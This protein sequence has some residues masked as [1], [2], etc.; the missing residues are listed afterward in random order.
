MP[1]NFFLKMIQNLRQNEEI[2]LYGNVLNISEQDAHDVV[3]FLKNE[4]RQEALSYPYEAPI[5][6]EN[7]ALWAAKLAYIA[8][9]LILYRK[10]DDAD[11]ETLLPDYQNIKT[12]SSI[13]SAD[14]CLR[15]LPDMII[16]LKIIDS[17]DRLIEVLENHLFQA[18]FSGLNYPLDI[19]KMDF[20]NIDA[21]KCVMQLFC[22]RIIE[23]KYLKLAEHSVFKDWIQAN[24]GIFAKE[25]WT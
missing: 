1:T 16:Q 19:E 12:P 5:F 18:P 20:S 17:A 13:L 4:Y 21:N 25:Y 22:N 6:D 15:F 7:A 23:N 11:L 8:A 2:M 9:Q 24:L 3:A 10:D 14:L